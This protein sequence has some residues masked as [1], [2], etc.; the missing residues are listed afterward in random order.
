VTFCL[1]KQLCDCC[2][3]FGSAEDVCGGTGFVTLQMSTGQI[4][5]ALILF[6]VVFADKAVFYFFRVSNSQRPRVPLK[7]LSLI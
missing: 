5:N 3:E 4:Q 6:E 7:C 1:G 2:S